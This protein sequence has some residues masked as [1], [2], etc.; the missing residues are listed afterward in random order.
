MHGPAIEI[1]MEPPDF[2][3]SIGHHF[4][5]WTRMN[6]GLLWPGP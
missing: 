1:R 4:G 5:V 3:M 6:T 2:G